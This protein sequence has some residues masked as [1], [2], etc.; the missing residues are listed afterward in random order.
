MKLTLTA[1]ATGT[2]LLLTA[3]VHAGG[4]VI[5]DTYEAEPQTQ[6]KAGWIVPVAILLIIAAAASGGSNGGGVC[7]GPDDVPVPPEGGCQ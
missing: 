3:P 2:A 1:I 7:N 6:G 5:E 4:P